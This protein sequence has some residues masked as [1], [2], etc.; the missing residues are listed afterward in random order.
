M[1]VTHKADRCQKLLAGGDSE[2]Q[3]H[4]LAGDGEND[5]RIRRR[6]CFHAHRRSAES[7]H[8]VAEPRRRSR[9]AGAQRALRFGHGRRVCARHRQAHLRH[10]AVR[11]GRNVS[12]RIHYRRLLGLEPADRH[13]R[14]DEHQ[15]ALSLRVSGTRTDLHV[16]VDDQ[17]GRR[18]AA[19]GA[20]RRRDAHRRA[21]GRQRRAG[22]RLSRH[23][24]GLVQQ[25]AHS[26][27][28]YLRRKRLPESACGALRAARAGCGARHRASLARSK[29][30][31][32]LRVAA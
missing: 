30:P 32:C 22:T 2:R 8:R 16:S 12:A 27:P 29:S 4:G 20:N 25:A 19:A 18:F 21:R 9:G 11:S 6:I 1:E 10:R 26:A 28:R 17:V 3:A 31:C 23:S 15:H 14:H 13:Q 7:A 5:A 24:G